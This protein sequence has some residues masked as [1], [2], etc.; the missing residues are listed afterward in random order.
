MRLCFILCAIGSAPLSVTFGMNAHPGA[1]TKDE[2]I[3]LVVDA[4]P[5]RGPRCPKCRAVIPQFADLTDADVACRARRRHGEAPQA[6][7][8]KCKATN[9]AHAIGNGHLAQ[10]EA[11][12]EGEVADV[13]HTIGNP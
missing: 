9:R 4:L 8:L 3:G 7:V 1:Y 12:R 2:L 5:T 13:R 10:T 11:V 6:G